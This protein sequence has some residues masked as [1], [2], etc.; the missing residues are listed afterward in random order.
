MIL[1]LALAA[2]AWARV[3]TCDPLV[4][5]LDNGAR[6][7]VEENHASPVVAVRLY[8][9]TG[10]VF[11]GR[12]LGSGISHFVEHCAGEGTPTRTKADIEQLEEALGGSR[13]AF[14]S[15]RMTCYYMNT[16]P[17]DAAKAIDL[18]GDY[19]LGAT[20]PPESVKTQQ[21][22]ISREIARGDDD[23]GREINDLFFETMFLSHPD[24]YRIIG[25][26]QPFTALTRDDLVAYHHERYTPDNLVAVV[27]GD[28]RAAEAMGR[29]EAALGKYLRRPAL[30]PTLPAEPAP[31]SIRRRTETREGLQ[32]AYLMIGFRGPSMFSPDMYPMD[33]AAYVLGN[34]ASSRL[35]SKLRDEMGLVDSIYAW[36]DTPDY[37]DGSFAAG[38]LL[39]PAKLAKAEAAILQEIERLKTEPVTASEL[40]R[41]K[42]QKES[43]LVYAGETAEGRASQLAG[44][45]LITGDVDFSRRY[46]AGIRAV[47]AQSI[48][49]AA[50]KYL[51]PD[52]RVVTVLRPPAEAKAATV[53]TPTRAGRTLRE[54]LANGLRVIIRSDPQVPAVHVFVA[55]EG[56][57]RSETAATNGVTHLMAQTLI[58]GTTTRTR[59]QIADALESVGGGI[60]AYS[61]RN[62]F[63]LTATV[64]P[65]DIAKALE[66]TA[67]CLE[68]PTFPTAELERERQLTLA[69][70]A[71]QNDDVDTVAANLLRDTLFTVHPYRFDE[72]GTAESAKGLSAEAVRS[73]YAAACRPERLVLVVLGNVDAEAT[74]AQ[75]KAR[76]G[77]WQPAP[78]Q[79]LP[80]P[81]PEP[82]IAAQRV[83]LETRPQQ[84][85]II[86]YGFPGSTVNDPDRY[87]QDV[88]TAVLAGI[89]V[90]S[91]R[92]HRELRNR[93]LVY[94]TFGYPV[95][96]VDP[97]F[98]AIYAGTPP[99]KVAEARSVIE[100]L[101]AGMRDTIV[102]DDELARAKQVAITAHDMGL[103]EP[104]SLAQTM[105]LN[106]LYG[107]GFDEYT[108]YTER[109]NAV[110]AQQVQEQARRLLDLQHGVVVVTTPPQ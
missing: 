105:G 43:E 87:A 41:A 81:S 27:V 42:K 21:G 55:G 61:G 35:V 79:A 95:R 96:G 34:G 80:K 30:I 23:P 78:A 47:T 68:N 37:G 83:K 45:L 75:V 17:P 67:D 19:V 20:F 2:I 49:A 69:A 107:L 9:G 60:S 66:V 77:S 74:M 84:Q 29:L 31:T 36:S 4:K 5:T 40:E 92:L 70:I 26:E 71:S 98:Y 48:Q 72:L 93:S 46:V 11:E 99:E 18:L 58:R 53:A 63:G 33:V 86:M 32:R 25:Y 109:I 10:S 14:T 108:H 12:W 104:A 13:N 91:G 15:K 73:Y 51:D 57:L 8:V 52:R 102:P 44:D 89:G 101:V 62:S 7:I 54:T 100:S 50:R 1:C 88:M 24:R 39:D 16:S 97:G 38:A 6:L 90:P 65:A 3:A 82:P 22:I 76:F 110:T 106:E 103:A 59:E 64:L 85:G 94:A 56:G 28:V